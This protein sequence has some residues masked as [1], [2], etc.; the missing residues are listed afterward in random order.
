MCSWGKVWTIRHKTAKAQLP[1]LRCQEK[2]QG[3]MPDPCS[4]HLWGGGQTTY[5][6]LPAWPS[7][8]PLPWPHLRNQLT[9]P[10]NQG[11][12][13]G[14][15]YFLSL[16]SPNKASPECSSS[17]LRMLSRSAMSDSLWPHGLWP[18]RFLC[19]ENF[20]GKNTRVDCHFLLPGDFPNPGIDPTSPASPALQADSLQ[21]SHHLAS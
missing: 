13:K 9:A 8:L 10:C 2:K 17:F 14:T 4:Q 21:L 20:P 6:T 11:V 16:V 18:S 19:P 1:L 5:A 3:T 12:S 7:D 15:C